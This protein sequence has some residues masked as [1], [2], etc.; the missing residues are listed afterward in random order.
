MAG[1]LCVVLLELELKDRKKKH[2]VKEKQCGSL[3]SL[4]G[5]LYFKFLGPPPYEWFPYF[6]FE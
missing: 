4:N 3:I 5:S 1:V 2:E 6:N